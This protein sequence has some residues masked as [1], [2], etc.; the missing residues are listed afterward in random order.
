MG[1]EKD[2]VLKLVCG[3]LHGQ[4]SRPWFATRT[5]FL[6]PSTDMDVAPGETGFGSKTP[7]DSGQDGGKC[8]GP[9]TSGGGF[10]YKPM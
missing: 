4:L 8:H 10:A 1:W 6:S 2:T 9:G 7:G 3:P 5:I